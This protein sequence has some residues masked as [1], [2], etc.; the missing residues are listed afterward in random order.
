MRKSSLLLAA[1]GTVVLIT[2]G[3]AIAPVASAAGS[4]PSDPKVCDDKEKMESANNALKGACVVMGRT[5]GNCASCHVIAGT[6][7]VGN[8]APPLVDMAKRFPDKAKLRAQIWDATAINP[9]SSMPPFGRHKILTEKE[10]DQVT[11]FV[12]TL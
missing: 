11:E 8:I 12:S 10:V 7:N 5:K 6:S 2:G 3:L 9:K 4:L 1:L